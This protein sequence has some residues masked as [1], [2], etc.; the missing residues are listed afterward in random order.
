MNFAEGADP[1]VFG[2]V[3]TSSSLPRKGPFVPE[4]CVV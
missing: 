3:V 2:S 4:P 1:T